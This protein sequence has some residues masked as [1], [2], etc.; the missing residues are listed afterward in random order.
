MY[1]RTF[2]AKKI[3]VP[4]SAT[5]VFSILAILAGLLITFFMTSEGPIRLIGICITILAGFGHFMLVSQR[6]SNSFESHRGSSA[7]PPEFRVTVMPGQAGKRMVFDGFESTLDDTR[8]AEFEKM[9]S[10]PIPQ[11]QSR[12]KDAEKL[13]QDEP[14][15]EEEQPMKASTKAP[16]II[17]PS[18]DQQSS[19]SEI[20][21]V[22][23][24]IRIIRKQ[25]SGGIVIKKTI[26]NDTNEADSV[27]IQPLETE[28]T[29][30]TPYP[31]I[32]QELAEP[33][34]REHIP[35]ESYQ[36]LEEEK[37]PSSNHK[38]AV[39]EVSLLDFMEENEPAPSEPR[40]EFD[41][42]LARVLM[43]IRS[44]IDARTAGFAWANH[45]KKQLVIE[46]Y[47]SESKD[48]FTQLRKLPFGNDVISQ[49]AHS[50]KPEILTEIHPSA[51]LDLLCY[52]TAAAKTISFIGVPVYFNGNVI[53]VLFA[54]S[55]QTDAYDA[56]SIGFLGNFT[57][58]ITGLVQSYTGKY[59]LLQASRALDAI[60]RFR[61]IIASSGDGIADLC[62]ALLESASEVVEFTT[63]GIGMFDYEQQAWTVYQV[64]YRQEESEKM[65]GMHI[66]LEYSL[67]GNTILTAQTTAIAPI[68]DEL[69]VCDSEMPANGGYFLAVPLKSQ[70]HN[71]GALFLEGSGTIL[72][73]HD[74]NIIEMLG[75]Q[76]GTI[77][78]QLRFHEMFRSTALM[79]ETK[80]L[81]NSKAFY[82]RMI[83]ETAKTRDFGN[84]FSLALIKMDTYES[85]ENLHEIEDDLLLH[86]IKKVKSNMK[87]YDIIG[88]FEG[89]TLAIALIGQSLEKSHIWG[90]RVRKE[91]ASAI[92]E[93][94]N[95]RLTVTVSIGIAQANSYD[96][97][98]SLIRN[99]TS[100][101]QL[102][103]EKTN[104]VIVYS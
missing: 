38:R 65:L 94:N 95:R 67:I 10:R 89:K 74:I 92:T 69:R 47:I 90:E 68:A 60:T 30:D 1:K 76:T 12:F 13:Q 45:D 53:G 73:S 19:L 55:D 62:T 72:P 9:R 14:F 71:Y 52:Y 91:I 34:I 97:A 17:P 40:K 82:A 20:E 56:M 83:E 50:G 42:L 22:G 104:S 66:D 5:E 31:I 18:T 63:M 8:A 48:N 103:S 37:E 88:E 32:E 28:F 75:E 84:P 54:D 44:V 49:I 24:G 11:V 21:D 3:L 26:Y 27:P 93:I 100:S 96:K 61:T 79:D 81:Y 51:E 58:L 80:G 35:E 46:S 41:F 29:V 99:A 36:P 86:V 7:V 98:D 78:E 102:A 15:V 16:P 23:E 70:S 59:D 39:L 4:A 87:E 6:L 33:I 64:Y 2:S 43:A 85:L 77:I 57:K 25:S 101:L